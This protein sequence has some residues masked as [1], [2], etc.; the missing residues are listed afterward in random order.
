ML[1][2]DFTNNNVSKIDNMGILKFNFSS[3]LFYIIQR[4]NIL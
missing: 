1:T 2:N 3:H 4:I